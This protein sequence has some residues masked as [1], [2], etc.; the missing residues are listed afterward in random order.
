MQTCEITTFTIS[1]TFQSYHLVYVD[2]SGC[3]KRVRFRRTG[4]SPIGMTPIQVSQFRRDQLYQNLPA[5]AQAGIVLFRVFQGSIDA[6]RTPLAWL[7]T[8]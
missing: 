7:K 8:E 6:S 5:Y 2:E 4:W 1:Q 3:D